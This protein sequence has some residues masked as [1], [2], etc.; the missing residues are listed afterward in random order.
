[1]HSLRKRAILGGLIWAAAIVVIGAIALFSFFE[2][3][4]Q[5]RF[6][7]GLMERHLQLIVALSNS[8][9]D[10]DLMEDYIP[11]AAYQRPY[12]GRY[13]QITDDA[14]TVYASRSLFDVTF[15]EQS[16]LTD[17]PTVWLGQ[18]PNGD[19]RGL[20]QHISLEDGSNWTVTV[21]ET[22]ANL[23]AEQSQIRQS[24]LAT[25]ALL[26]ALG[27]AGSILLASAIVRPLSKLR[28]DV[29][30]RWDEDHAFTPEDYPEEVAPLVSDINT[31]LDRNR[32]IVDRGRRQA[33]DMAHALKTP[34]AIMRNE[35]SALAEQKV[36]VTQAVHALDRVDA[37]IGR[38][39]ARIR[40]ANTGEG[41]HNQSNVKTSV[42]RISRLFTSL[43]VYAS[44]SLTVDVGADIN[45]PMDAQDLEEILGNSLEN[46]FN[47]AQQRVRIICHKNERTTV[48]EVH[49]DGP[50]I[51]EE[52]R[53]KALRSGGRLDTAI[54]G[55]GLGLAIVDDLMQ[56]YGGSVELARSDVLGGL[57]VML[58]IPSFGRQ[59][60]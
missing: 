11:D 40:A 46:A 49:D 57:V 33:A 44:K 39:L 54:P 7:N 47:W 20:Q 5:R 23:Y 6:D 55:T 12:S 35:L 10:P 25:F 13:W 58:S 24:L 56:A 1:M 38:S 26:G 37:Q 18:G 2:T 32:K 17:V 19:V 34:S 22:M 51:A 41:S 21:A 15:A 3:L 28:K 4:A 53:Q 52:D 60:G 36:D 27:I 14:G 16:G 50:G 42:D 8:D 9:G 30:Q 45:V 43:P 59:K 31:L 48:L 29:A